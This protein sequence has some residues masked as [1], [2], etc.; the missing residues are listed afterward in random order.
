[1]ELETQILFH[2]ISQDFFVGISWR[3]VNYS[4]NKAHDII[5]TLE[6]EKHAQ[7]EIREEDVQALNCLKFAMTLRKILSNQDMDK[8]E[9]LNAAKRLQQ[10]F[11]QADSDDDDDM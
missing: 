5:Q 3:K 1:M 4:L 2:K 9:K 7:A 6:T 8:N 10:Q 11:I